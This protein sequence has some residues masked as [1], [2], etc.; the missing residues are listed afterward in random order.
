M[1]KIFLSAIA[2]SFCLLTACSDDPEPST[3]EKCEGGLN[4]D[5]LVG[6][7]NL[8]G[9]ESTIDKS[10]IV[11]FGVA[12]STLVFTDDGKFEFTTTTSPNSDMAGRGCAGE[13]TYG[14]WS[15][16]GASLKIIVKMARCQEPDAGTYTTTPT[17]NATDLN[18]NKLVFHSNDISD[19]FIK[20]NATEHYIRAA[21]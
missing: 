9:I 12:P 4:E 18:F 21:D 13:K 17:I 8:N 7:W 20:P 11:D 6:T 15:I 3:E 14:E 2:A 16:E 1:K 5:C 19:A 10:K